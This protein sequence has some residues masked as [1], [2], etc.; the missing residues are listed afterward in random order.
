[1]R[2]GVSMPIDPPTHRPSWLPRKATA[3]EYDRAR[4][5]ARQRG[6]DAQ[7]ERLRA[8]V[9]RERPCCEAPGCGSRE[10]LNVDHI[11]SVR[12]APERRLDRTNLR[13][14]CQPCH[15]ARTARD[16]GFGRSGGR[17]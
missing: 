3:R 13:V 14:L 15:S 11:V 12:L 9:L 1:M 4:G 16:Q 7:W 2:L 5:S 17:G 6:Y 8:E 10:R